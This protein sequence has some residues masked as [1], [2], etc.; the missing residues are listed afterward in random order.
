MTLFRIMTMAGHIACL[1]IN[2]V[3]AVPCGIDWIQ[4]FRLEINH[5]KLGI[6]KMIEPEFKIVRITFSVI[7]TFLKAIIVSMCA[8]GVVFTVHKLGIHMSAGFPKKT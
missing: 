7:R 4:G 1:H 8:V 5:L 3:V 2:R 6:V